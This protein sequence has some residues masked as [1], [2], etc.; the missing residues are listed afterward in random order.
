MFISIK[1]P[2]LIKLWKAFLKLKPQPYLDKGIKGT[3]EY[4]KS[5]AIPETPVDTG[6][7][8]WGYKIEYNKD[9]WI[10]VNSKEYLW[11][12]HEGTRYIKGNPFLTELISKE[13][14]TINK[15][16]NKDVELMLN[17]LKI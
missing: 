1:S 6:Q 9:S 7:L 12:V 11:F 13:D 10:L 16:F 2:D 15:V 8:K 4:I 14:K 3:M 17:Q 5:K